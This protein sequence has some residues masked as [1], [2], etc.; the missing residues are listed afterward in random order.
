MPTPPMKYSLN[1][2]HVTQRFEADGGPKLESYQ[3]S[4]GIWTIAWG[5]TKGVVAGIVCTLVQ[6]KAWLVE[7]L[8]WAEN[9]VNKLVRVSLTQGEFDA[10]VDFTFNCGAGNFDHS[11][12]LVLVNAGDMKAAALEFDKWDHCAG[13]VVAGL[14]R[15]REAE[16]ALFVS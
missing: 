5:H 2:Q 14:L 11:S 16:T 15:R 4:R 13:K 8:Q 12:L 10:L 7:D 1:G 6:A 9:E 3:D